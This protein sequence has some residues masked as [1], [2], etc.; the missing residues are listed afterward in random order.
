MATRVHISYDIGM[1]P[2][3]CR[4]NHPNESYR[5]RDHLPE[6]NPAVENHL[7]NMVTLQST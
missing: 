6:Q 4:R 2:I 7:Q 1:Y 3:K 5:I